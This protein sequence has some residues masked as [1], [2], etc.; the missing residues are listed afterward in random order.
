[1]ATSKEEKA[2][3]IQ[4]SR[5]DVSEELR[6]FEFGS[7]HLSPEYSD[8]KITCGD[9]TFFAHKVIVCPQSAYF[10]KACSGSFKVLC[11]LGRFSNYIRV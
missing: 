10:R 9:K 3:L 5:K 7:L 1:M 2:I 8:L 6:S 4:V 11:S